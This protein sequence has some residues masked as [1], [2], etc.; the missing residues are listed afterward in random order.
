MRNIYIYIGLLLALSIPVKGQ[1]VQPESSFNKDSVK[2]GE[3]V[4]YS[5]SIR[6]LST[7]DVVFPDSLFNFAPFELYKKVSFPTRSDSIFSL[8]SAVY[9]L[10]TFELD[11]VQ[12]LNLPIFMVLCL[13]M[14]I[15]SLFISDSEKEVML[16]IV[17]SP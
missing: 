14:S 8:D 9:H 3:E 2:I 5:R 4:V 12:L 10:S 17:S 7:K 6:Y 15:Y 13:N 16:F 1:I 11:T